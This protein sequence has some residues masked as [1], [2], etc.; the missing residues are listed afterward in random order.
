MRNAQWS[1]PALGFISTG[2][3]AEGVAGAGAWCW[4]NGSGPP[5][6]SLAVA[7][8]SQHK[9]PLMGPSMGSELGVSRRPDRAVN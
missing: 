7:L 5:Q 9:A 4:G 6:A 3:G 8:G 1:Q 2:Q